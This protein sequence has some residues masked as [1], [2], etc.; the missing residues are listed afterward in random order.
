MDI[1]DLSAKITLDTEGYNKGIEQAR[2][3]MGGLSAF[4][5]AKGQL[6]YEGIKTAGTALV[7]LGKKALEGYADYEQ[8]V[9]GVETLF[10]DSADI[11]EGYAEKAYQTAGLSA[12]QY[13]ET[14]T[15]FSASLLQSVGGNTAAAAEYANQAIVDMSDNANKMGTDIKSI[16]NAYQGFAKQN[17]TMLD[18]LKLGYGG[19]K[20]EMERLIADAN[21]VKA[22]NGEMADLSIDSFADVTEAIHIIQTEMDITGTTAE[23]A[24]TTI[25][26]S[27]N[28]MKSAFDNLMTGIAGGSDNLDTLVEEFFNSVGTVAENIVPVIGDVLAGLGNFL[29]EAIPKV[30]DGAAE[31]IQKLGDYISEHADEIVQKGIELLVNLVQGII[32]A[33]PKIA[34]AGLKII[35]ALAKAIIKNA[36]QLIATVPAMIANIMLGLFQVFDDILEIG[37]KIVSGIWEGIK[38]MFSWITDKIKDFFDRILGGI[39]KMLGIHSPS[40]VFAGIGEYMAA[41]IGEGWNSE[42]GKI[43]DGINSDMTFNAG[44]VSFSTDGQYGAG[45]AA[46]GGMVSGGSAADIV[47]N[48]TSEIDGEVLSRKM[49]RINQKEQ[50]RHGPAFVMA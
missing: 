46:P 7:T 40:K 15:S 17:Y 48:L 8:L 41:G 47:I 49:F 34:E 23:E 2:T 45:S 28:S 29:V 33:I 13:M 9:G 10:K 11:V 4:T 43:K 38:S 20:T 6:I 35:V 21:R 39:K 1:F 5:V 50:T 12:N 44:K 42:F 14:V 31:L 36:P 32:K 30:I 26:G 19:T 16:Q 24:S 25:E 18:N 37:R 22:A 3:G 27:V